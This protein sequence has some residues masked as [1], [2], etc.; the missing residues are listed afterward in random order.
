MELEGYAQHVLGPQSLGFGGNLMRSQ[1]KPY[2]YRAQ[3]PATALR[4]W[5]TG[6]LT[7]LVGKDH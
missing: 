3:L 1:T 6:V 5:F 4:D 2:L 7:S